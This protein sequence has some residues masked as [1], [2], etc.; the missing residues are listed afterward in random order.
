M[1]AALW[2]LGSAVAGAA[3]PP[4]TPVAPTAGASRPVTAAPTRVS[5]ARAAAPEPPRSAAEGPLML[6]AAVDGEEA[7]D[8]LDEDLRAGGAA[9]AGRPEAA[10]RRSAEEFPAVPFDPAFNVSAAPTLASLK[11]Y[12]LVFT[13]VWMLRITS[14]WPQT[15]AN[16]T[17]RQLND[18]NID[19]TLVGPGSARGTVSAM[20]TC[21]AR[22]R[23]ACALAD[24]VGETMCVHPGKPRP[25][26]ADIHRGVAKGFRCFNTNTIQVISRLLDCHRR[27]YSISGGDDWITAVIMTSYTSALSFL[28]GAAKKDGPGGV[29][30][31]IID[32]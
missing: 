16:V 26:N 21:A 3:T 14:T 22:I 25:T 1:D 30:Q 4:L 32:C 7:C 8:N 29:N 9:A 17:R 31:V 20:K 5:S 6:L 28:V 27:G 2:S 24:S 19:R 10:R 12:G 23:I 15:A 11:E 18:L 13:S